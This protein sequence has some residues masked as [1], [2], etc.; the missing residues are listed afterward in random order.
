M[1]LQDDPEA[2]FRKAMPDTAPPPARFDLDRIVQDGYRARRRHRAALGAAATGGVA[3]VAAVLALS[4]AGFPG[5]AEDPDVPN[6]P[7]AGEAEEFA[8]AGYPYA[9]EDRF[10]TEEEREA[11]RTAAVDAFGPLLLDTGVTPAEHLEMPTEEEIQEKMEATGVGY[12]EAVS[13]LM[14]YG[15]P[16]E[17]TT[18]QTPGNYGQTWLRSYTSGASDED[19]DTVLRLEAMLPGGWTAE[20]GPV[21]EQVFPQHLISASAYPWYEEADWTDE[22]V[23]TDLDDGR[24]LITVDHE[25]AYEAAVVYPNGSG[26]RA[27]W[28]MGCE[29]STSEYGVSME[30]F[31]AAATAMPEVDYDTSELSP[32]DEL[33]EVPTGWLY[34]AEWEQSDTALDGADTTMAAALDAL[35]EVE[36]E[37]TLDGPVPVQLG[38]TD[39]GAVVTRS[40]YGSGTLPYETTID[41]T[42]GDV[43]FDLRYYLPGGWVPGIDEEGGRGP[44][45]LV[46]QEEF[47][48]SETTDDDGTVWVF[49]ELEKEYHDDP[50][51]EDYVEHQLQVTR[52]D[53]DGWAVSVWLQWQNDAP[54]DTDLLGDVLRAMPA[55]EYDEEAVPTVPEN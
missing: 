25:C 1:N 44:Y 12:D 8:M 26:F 20:P 42:T 11:L 47:A 17:F 34:D 39:R 55:P 43:G 29:E 10:G 52:F 23:T 36:P 7:A 3:A 5:I 30:D 45:V 32:V 4:V 38:M 53:P 22:L 54:I 6:P 51:G 16:L 9:P 28:D 33:V 15:I 31:S 50:G 49:E 24:T 46:C 13:L 48:C 14:P 27:S 2:V 18:D 40:Y 21:T 41:E 35:R 19:G 37:G